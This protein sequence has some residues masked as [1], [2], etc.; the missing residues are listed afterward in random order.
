MTTAA[1]PEH[2]AKLEAAPSASPLDAHSSPVAETG[3]RS[4]QAVTALVLGIL[5]VLCALLIPI[6]GLILGVL[7]LVFGRQ[8]R[9]EVGMTGRSGR[10]Q[11][12]A[13]FILGIVAIV[14][15]VVMMI[16]NAIILTS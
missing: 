10:A 8:A 3:R 16:V 9:R 1:G 5:G 2:Q 14:G 13:G 4:G 12:Q 7:A 11:A 15:A 6:V